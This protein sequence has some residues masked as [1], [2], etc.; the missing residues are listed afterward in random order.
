MGT[1]I[2]PIQTPWVPPNVRF[3]LE[4][5]NQAEWSW[6]DNTFDFVHARELIGSIKDWP[7]FYREA[8]R[9]CKPGGYFEHFDNSCNI[10]ADDGTVPDDSPISQYGKVMWEGGKKFGQTFR[11]YEDDVQKKGMEAAGFVDIVTRDYKVPFT[12]WPADPDLQEQGAW[13]KLATMGDIHG[14]LARLLCSSWLLL[15]LLSLYDSLLTSRRLYRICLEQPPRMEAGGNR[16]LHCP[17]PT[18]S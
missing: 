14:T 7:A 13:A 1:D 9:I 5:A 2:T 10:F 18:T 8:Y 4:D 6:P 3:E 15:A 12:P 17:F 16:G 11:I